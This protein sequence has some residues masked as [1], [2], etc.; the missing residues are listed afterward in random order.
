MII[1]KLWKWTPYKSYPRREALSTHLANPQPSETGTWQNQQTLDVQNGE[2]ISVPRTSSSLATTSKTIVYGGDILERDN[3]VVCRDAR[4]GGSR[5]VLDPGEGSVS[6]HRVA[7][8]CEG[9]F[10]RGGLVGWG[11][12]G[13]GKG[14]R[15][16]GGKGGRWEGGGLLGWATVL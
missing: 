15:W 11:G 14:G 12:M 8:M 1:Q 16:D 3:P 4:T 2:S 6:I 9:V 7:M 5:D 10:L 13:G